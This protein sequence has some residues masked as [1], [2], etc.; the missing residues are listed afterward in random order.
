MKTEIYREIEI[1]LTGV[2]VKC[3]LGI[4]RT[5]SWY[6]V[7]DVQIESV[8][9]FGRSWTENELRAEFGKLA[10]WIIENVDEQEWDYDE[11]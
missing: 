8:H 7:E 9:M 1:E 11:E 2:R 5:P 6:E 10:D 4:P 3:D